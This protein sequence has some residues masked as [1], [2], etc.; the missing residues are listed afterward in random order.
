MRMPMK[1]RF[2]CLTFIKELKESNWTDSRSSN[3]RL[4]LCA[5]A[6]PLLI[7]SIVETVCKT[8]KGL[9]KFSTKQLMIKKVTRV[10]RSRMLKT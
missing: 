6:T 2:Y 3:S 1:I 8:L 9:L 4:K 5:W 7:D 10:N